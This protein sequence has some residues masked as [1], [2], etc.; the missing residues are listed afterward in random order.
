MDQ[1]VKQHR[2]LK[3]LWLLHKPKKL[4]QSHLLRPGSGSGPRRPDPDPTKKVRIRPDPDPQ[5]C[6]QQLQILPKRRKF[7][8]NFWCQLL[9]ISN[10]V[11]ELSENRIH[12]FDDRIVRHTTMCVENFKIFDFM[13]R[14][15]C[16]YI[17]SDI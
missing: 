7:F 17:V 15:S 9:T 5:R 10:C 4:I 8:T 11:T 1:K 14:G 16:L 6:L 2:F 13:H 12:S 3:Y